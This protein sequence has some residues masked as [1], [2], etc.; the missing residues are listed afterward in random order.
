MGCAQI[1]PVDCS[2]DVSL[3]AEDAARGSR[4]KLVSA[5]VPIPVVTPDF[6]VPP[7]QG[8]E[9]HKVVLGKYRMFMSKE[10]IMGE[11]SSS[12]CRRG[13]CIRTARPVAIKMYKETK[14]RIG[15]DAVKNL[16][17]Q[18]Q[19]HVLQQ[20][21]K[22]FQK[23][24]DRSLWHEQ[25]AH[26]KP[27]KLFMQLVDYSQDENGK[28]VA[29][30]ADGVMYIV[31]ELAQY[32]LKDYLGVRRDQSRPLPKTTVREIARAIIFVVAGLHAKGLVHIDLKPENLMMF[33]GRLK[34][35]DVDG[36][37]KIGT[38]VS[39]QDSSISFS[40][41]YCAPEWAKFLTESDKSI[42]VSPALDAWSV[43]MTICELV[44]L[45]AVLKPT[46]ADFLK[47]GHS[48]KE[49]GFLFMEWLA[50]IKKAPLPK[51]VDQSGL[52]FA[53]MITK[54]LLVTDHRKRRTLAECLSCPY[55]AKN[56]LSKSQAKKR[57][58]A[59]HDSCD[60][61]EVF[62]ESAADVQ[63]ARK[64]RGSKEDPSNQPLHMGTLWKLNKGG[65]PNDPT[66]WLKRDM[67]IAAN[68]SLCYFSHQEDTSVVLL[69]SEMLIGSKM[70]VF[71]QGAIKHAFQ[72]VVP[73][74]YAGERQVIVFGA[75]NEKEIKK[76]IVQ[77]TRAV[78][79]N[80]EMTMRLGSHTAKELKE[81]KLSVKN[82]RMRVSESTRDLFGP[83]FKAT[84]WKVKA[85]GDRTKEDDWFQRDMWL[86]KNGSLVYW[87]VKDQA[88]LVYY[89]AADLLQARVKRISNG[90]S[91][92]PWSFQ[93][94]VANT[95][96]FDFTPGEFAAE[97]GDLRELWISEFERVSQVYS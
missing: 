20:L 28:P 57:E 76:W 29:D 31:T 4:V 92:K 60:E 51:S 10:D 96:G 84:L 3:K 30:E 77:L 64:A 47:N 33:N 9:H 62:G 85:A 89:T 72:I 21:Q 79:L 50:N 26:V 22:P 38:K 43:G 93:I 95:N 19:I 46:Y 44:H 97:S 6:A 34:L 15:D 8:D 45:D 25:L 58:V 78:T 12:I 2:T 90:M 14:K 36:C 86:A 73:E 69:D 70:K 1:I 40:P 37:V 61:E 17:F 75:E 83:S 87:S 49:A 13:E 54:W 41:C 18:R 53:D 63:C 48:H 65:D 88:E 5:L 67:W 11:G 66:Q 27:S 56:P 32:S 94:A 91:A 35:I 71:P 24:D 39:I 59:A 68:G 55:I 82:R 7:L 81:F 74:K 16:K 23:C 52:D 42:V 80:M